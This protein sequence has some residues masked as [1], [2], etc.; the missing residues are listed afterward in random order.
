M[1]TVLTPAGYARLRDAAPLHLAG[2]AE[3]MLQHV[4]PDELAT[5][6]A[7]LARIAGAHRVP[8][9]PPDDAPG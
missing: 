7:V 2:V 9:A 4:R 1:F 8:A 6:G 3:H 5:L